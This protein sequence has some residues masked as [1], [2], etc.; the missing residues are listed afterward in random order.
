MDPRWP[1]LFDAGMGGSGGLFN[2][3]GFRHFGIA[4]DDVEFL[5]FWRNGNIIQPADKGLL[6]SAW[7]RPGKIMLQLFNYGLD[8]EGQEKTRSGKLK[9]NLQALGAPANLQPGQLRIREVAMDGHRVDGRS[10]QFDWYKTLLEQLRW[11]KDEKP[12]LRPESNPIISVDGT[13]DNI[14]IY[15]H[16]CRFLE[17]TWDEIPV[18]LDAVTSAFGY[19]NLDNTL[20]WGYSRAKSADDMVKTDLANVS[21]KAWKQPG[22]AML[23]VK[24]NGDK[25]S[26]V[27]IKADLDKLGVKVP[28]VWQ[29]YTQCIGGDLDAKSGDITIKNLKAG[30]SKI[31]FIDTFAE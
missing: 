3:T 12:R 5:G 6:V 4:A 14:Q 11:P 26:E 7:K 2:T 10:A 17:I 25:L 19:S 29:A 18:S 31:I 20:N 24:N 16:D 23:L 8:P 15:Y 21:V 28:K 13:V 27:K 1:T 30:E 9:L 22:T